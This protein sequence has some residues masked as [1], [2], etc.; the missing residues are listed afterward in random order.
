MGIRK[1]NV[2]LLFWV[3]EEEKQTIQTRMEQIGTKNM[4]AYLRKM[5]L[6]GLLISLSIPELKE[7]LTLMRRSSNNLNQ[8]A[9]RVNSN[10]RLYGADLEDIQK[11]QDELWKIMRQL[12]LQ[13]GKIP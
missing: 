7:I 3:T 1:R 2:P 4:S 11:R 13:I 9:K 6:N 5:A 12:L 8:L 10:G